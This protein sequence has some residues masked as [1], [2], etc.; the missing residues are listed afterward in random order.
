MT[1]EHMTHICE[2][3]MSVVC[4]RFIPVG[5]MLRQRVWNEAFGHQ[6]ESPDH[7]KDAAGRNKEEGGPQRDTTL[8]WQ[9]QEKQDRVEIINSTWNECFPYRWLSMREM[10]EFFSPWWQK[11][12]LRKSRKPRYTK[13]WRWS[14]ERRT[15]FLPLGEKLKFIKKH[16]GLS[17]CATFSEIM[18]S[19]LSFF[20]FYSRLPDCP[21]NTPFK[22]TT[23]E[24]WDSLVF[25][26]RS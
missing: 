3:V 10:C 18:F 24:I 8:I 25:C 12:A 4:W 7:M 2:G 13:W 17:V 21:G 26:L 22:L 15:S 11:R 6:E 19:F 9:L 5:V 14:D 23:P 1:H 20:F 16:L